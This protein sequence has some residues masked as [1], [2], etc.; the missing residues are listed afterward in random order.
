MLS[1]ILG[2]PASR[3]AAPESAI[4]ILRWK[5]FRFA[6]REAFQPQCEPPIRYACRAAWRVLAMLPCL[7]GYSQT[8]L[9]AV[10]RLWSS[11]TWSKSPLLI[12]T[13][14]TTRSL[15]VQ[16]RGVV[17]RGGRRPGPKKSRPATVPGRAILALAPLR[18]AR[19]DT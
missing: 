2:V 5:L 9:C 13:S 18:C 3:Y 7:S 8:L 11:W 4:R 6:S 10:G 16:Q 15:S 19:R 17:P 1:G 14:W 12:A